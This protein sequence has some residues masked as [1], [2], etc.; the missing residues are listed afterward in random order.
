[1]R[2]AGRAIFGVAL[3][4]VG[5]ARPDPGRYGITSIEIEGNDALDSEAIEACLISRERAHFGVRLGLSSPSCGKPPFDSSPPTLRLWRW[6][7]TEW[8][9]FNQAVFDQDVERVQRF[10]RARGYYEARIVKVEVTPPEARVPGKAGECDPAAETCPVSVLVVV[11]EGLPTHVQAV[12][13]RGLSGLP[14]E[15]AERCRRAPPLAAG[16]VVDE[17][18]YEQGKQNLVK[19][20]RAAGH[21]A[22][23]VEG[24]V[25]VDTRA[26]SARIMY[27]I[28]AGPVYRIGKVTVRG[29]SGYAARVV[30]AA[31]GLRGGARYDPEA[32]AEAQGEVYAMGA[33]SAAQMHETLRPDAREVDVAIEVTPLDPNAF[34]VSLGIMSGAVQ[35][36]ST[37]ELQSVPQWDVHLV[38]SYERR[39][40]FGSLARLRIEERPRIIY[41]DDF[42]RPTPPQ[43]GNIVKLGVTYPG[44][45]EP[46]TESFFETA[47]DYGPEP[48]LGFVRSDIYFR[49][50]S[51]R[52]FFRGALTATL[53]LQQDLFLVDPSPD[54]VSS[55]GE[56]Q[57]SYGISYLEQD[58]RLDFRNNP[59]RPRSGAYFGLRATEAPRWQGSDWT[60]FSL[61]PEARAFAPLFWDV[62]WATRAA[63]GSIFITDASER[64]DPVARALGPTAYRLRGGGAYSNRGFLAGDLGAGPT[65]GIRR[66]ELS[67]ELRIPFG[68]SFVLAGFFDLGDVNDAPSFRFNHLNATA[69]HG[70]RYYTVLGAIRLDFGY[71]I[72]ALQRADGSNGIEPD[73]DELWLIGVPGAIHLTI[74]DAF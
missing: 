33:F 52:R 62:V 20:L 64:L 60:A 63:L 4:L 22:A 25:A 2:V 27:E 8:P 9:A 72:P 45:I 46:R 51:R 1:M 57:T 10:Y 3:A 31:A 56:P 67:S 6:P 32:I 69:G 12:E 13:L 42:P 41:E 65:G 61:S 24:S 66:W 11:D 71:R 23:K 58:L 34:R 7:W 48:F 73:A 15:L 53:A 49:L 43:F 26:R 68:D 74:G 19:E 18:F 5:C 39:H 29:L 59:A 44:L 38:T 40:L 16:A 54:N 35:R 14:G 37:S 28:E 70:F 47:W 21:A 36:T 17:E 55:D 30:H 50:G